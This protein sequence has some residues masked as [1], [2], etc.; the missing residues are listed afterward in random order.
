MSGSE[1]II[2]NTETPTREEPVRTGPGKNGES[3]DGAGH[4]QKAVCVL[5]VKEAP[6]SL[7]VSKVTFL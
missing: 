6:D 5:S 3:R 7:R 1:A 4:R 2:E